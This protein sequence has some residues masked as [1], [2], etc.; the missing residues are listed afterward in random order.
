MSRWL[1]VLVLTVAAATA[2]AQPGRATS[3]ATPTWGFANPRVAD[4]LAGQ[5]SYGVVKAGNRRNRIGYD[6]YF[7]GADAA[8]DRE[9][10]SQ[11]GIGTVVLTGG[12]QDLLDGTSA[13]ELQTQTLEPIIDR[14][15]AWGINVV[16][17]DLTP[18][19][20]Y[21]ACTPEID[22]ARRVVNGWISDQESFLPPSITPVGFAQAVSVDDPA[23]T[24]TPPD[25]VL[26]T[27]YDTGDHVNLT[28][29]GF[30]ALAG[31]IPIP[32]LAANVPPSY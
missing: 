31:T 32:A 11:P 27:E 2:W 19:R 5:G 24:A 17:G 14:L 29:A 20:G 3:T 15:Q 22:A 8:L 23:G 12:L 7:S 10:L 13:T 4:L 26:G 16:L 6:G 30:A 28:K 9:V 25:Q 21:A 18:C 1:L